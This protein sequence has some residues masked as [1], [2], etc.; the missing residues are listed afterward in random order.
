[1]KP[2]KQSKESYKYLPH[3]KYFAL[4]DRDDFLTPI[5]ISVP[6]PPKLEFID[7]YAV[8]PEEEMFERI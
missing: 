6:E 5:Y 1:M 3:D 4:N 7:G 2:Q 8:P